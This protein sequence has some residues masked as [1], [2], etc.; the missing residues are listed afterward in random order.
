MEIYEIQDMAN[1]IMEMCQ[2]KGMT[3][4]E[5]TLTLDITKQRICE[6]KE[7]AMEEAGDYKLKFKRFS[8]P[9]GR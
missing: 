5:A 7:R 1:K 3:F 4:N 2:K 8:A 9:Q 6:G